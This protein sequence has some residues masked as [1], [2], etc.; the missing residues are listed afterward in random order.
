MQ[1]DVPSQGDKNNP[2]SDT[3][4]SLGKDLDSGDLKSAQAD[5]A[6]IKKATSQNPPGGRAGGTRGANGTVRAAVPNPTRLTT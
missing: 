4:A 2:L 5:Y 6:K 3:I 1:K